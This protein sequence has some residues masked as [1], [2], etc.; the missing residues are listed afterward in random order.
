[1]CSSCVTY[2][3]HVVYMCRDYLVSES[4]DKKGV[5]FDLTSW[6]TS[7]PKDIPHQMN[8][9]DCGVFTCMV[10]TSSHLLAHNA[11][12]IIIVVCISSF[13]MPGFFQLV[14]PFNFPK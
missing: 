11:L 3:S 10:S 6:T 7:M 14:L 8:G 9:S 5:D 13:S 1:M 4:K 2:T 12:L